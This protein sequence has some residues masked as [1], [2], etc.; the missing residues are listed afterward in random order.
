MSTKGFLSSYRV[1]ELV[2]VSPSTV[3]S[4]IDQGLLPA[5]RTPG[6]HRRVSEAALC[7]FLRDRGLPLPPALSPRKQLLLIDDEAAFLRT[8]RRTLAQLAPRIETTTAEGG[9]DGLLH[10]GWLRPDAVVLDAYMPGMDGVEVCRRIRGFDRTRHTVVVALT[11]QPSE[12]LAER[13]R[14]AGAAACLAKPV[15]AERLLA[16]LGWLPDSDKRV[17]PAAT[18]REEVLEPQAS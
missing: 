18:P 1:A 12:E 16:A 17:E 10:V 4:W 9:I 8:T 7:R 13:F 11:G 6:G 3:L 15:A 14:E 2:R 5:H